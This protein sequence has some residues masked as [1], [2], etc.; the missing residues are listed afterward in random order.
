MRS[1]AASCIGVSA[2]SRATANERAGGCLLAVVAAGAGVGLAEDEAADHAAQVVAVLGGV[3]GQP[4]E[5]FG[6]ARRR[7][8]SASG[9]SG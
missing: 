8:R 4:L 5:Q 3:A 2:R 1:E 6:V 9:P 7:S